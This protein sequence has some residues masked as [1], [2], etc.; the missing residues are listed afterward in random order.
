MDLSV[1]SWQCHLDNQVLRT[2]A[3]PSSCLNRSDWHCLSLH[4]PFWQNKVTFENLVIYIFL[5][6][7]ES[8]QHN[9]Y[10]Y[11]AFGVNSSCSRRKMNLKGVPGRLSWDLKKNH[12]FILSLSTGVTSRNCSPDVWEESHKFC[13][14]LCFILPA[15]FPKMEISSNIIERDGKFHSYL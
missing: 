2:V 6:S 10:I 8:K 12:G 3:L 9:Q 1:V 14:S 5:S 13:F 11:Y 7:R 15:T 4:S